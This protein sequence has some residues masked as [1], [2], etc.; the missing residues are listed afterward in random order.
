M[1]VER[2]LVREMS[3]VHGDRQRV[4][5]LEQTRELDHEMMITVFPNGEVARSFDEL[6]KTV[7]NY[8]GPEVEVTRFPP[9]V[10]G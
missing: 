3:P 9:M 8:P 2:L 1:A 10:G 7:Q 5:T 6:L 4:L